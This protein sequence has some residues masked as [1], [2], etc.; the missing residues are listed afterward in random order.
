MLEDRDNHMAHSPSLKRL[1]SGQHFIEHDPKAPNVSTCSYRNPASL[2]RRHVSN[3]AH[4]HPGCGVKQYF[5]R[6][7]G[8]GSFCRAGLLSQLSNTEVQNFHITIA[9]N[10]DVLGL[11]IAMHDSRCVCGRQRRG[12]LDSD[13]NRFSQRYLCARQALPER[14]SVDELGRYEMR[15]V[16]LANLVNG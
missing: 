5:R 14:F 2:F 8:I 12:D 13:V 3:S 15:G 16:G 7:F 1:V 11:D 6:P 10:H 9:A 4:D